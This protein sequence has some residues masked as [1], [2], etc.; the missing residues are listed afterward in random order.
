MSSLQIS[1]P[2]RDPGRW[3]V[4]YSV[5]VAALAV[6]FDGALMGLIAPAVAL[7][8]GADA[9]TIG[10]IS[11]LNML[12]LAAFIL[13]GGTL[14]DIYG[15]KRIL[16]VGLLGAVLTSTLAILSPFASILMPVR[17]IS[18]IMAALVNPLALA[19]IMVTF[20]QEERSKALGLYAA[21]IGVVGGLG[22]IIIAYLNQQFGWRSTFGLVIL[23]AVI[24]FIMVRRFVQE[25]KAGDSKKVDWIGI[26]LTAA[27]L[28][29]IVYGVNQAAT[30]G[31]GSSVVLIPIGIGIVLLVILIF[32]SQRIEAPAL[33]LS[34]FQNKVF[35]VGVLLYLMMGFAAMG[36][37][38]QLSTYLQSLQQVSPIQAA[39]TLLPY[40]L[41]LFIFAILAG[42]WVGKF[43]N[44]MLIGGGMVLMAIGLVAMSLWLTPAA[45]FWVFLL[46]LVLLGGGQSIANVPRMSAV[47][48]TAPPELAGIASATNNASIQLGNSL[49]IAI[50]GAMFQGL[51][52]K[53]YFTSLTE[54]GLDQTTIQK[55]VEVL[56]AW[57][58]TNAGNVA[59]KFGITVQ[60]LE[61]VISNYEHAYT[62]GVVQ[63][64]WVGAAVVTIG[65]VMAWFTFQDKGEK[66]K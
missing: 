50:M 28:F 57:L 35:S 32:Y 65:A 6:V 4:L 46:P 36:P 27:G 23:L 18:G 9:A 10:L 8:L 38:F 14:G 59:S 60:Q 49:G 37:F 1:N 51:A 24:A 12:M 26:L 7:D 2:E 30:Q 62:S 64:L 21:A 41:A 45:G 56:G 48:A 42:G 22:M 29:T 61:G 40:T 11:S 66:M 54:K 34:L 31:F 19:I 55:S 63:V 33:R 58:K 15:R 43:A 39:I 47:L 3:M 52:R 13:G 5:I 16:M 44:R 17:A 20:D 25:S 53:T